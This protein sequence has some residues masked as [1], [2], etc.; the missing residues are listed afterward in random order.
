MYLRLCRHFRGMMTSSI[1]TFFV[2]L[3]ICVGNSLVTSEFSAHAKA[4]DTELWCFIWSAPEWTI[5]KQ[6]RGRWFET[7]SRSLWLHCN[8]VQRKKR[9]VAPAYLASRVRWSFLWNRPRVRERALRVKIGWVA[10]LEVQNGPSKG[11]NKG[12]YLTYSFY[13]LSIANK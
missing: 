4:S 3:T 11:V 6:S 8:G 10:P 12:I 13:P 1:G 2:L 9:T 5:G 7:L